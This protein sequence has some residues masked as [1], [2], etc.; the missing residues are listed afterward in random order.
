MTL[1]GTDQNTAAEKLY[2]HALTVAERIPSIPPPANVGEAD[3]LKKALSNYAILLRKL[4][5]DPEAAKLEARAA[6]IK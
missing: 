6:A 4:K 5:R 1:E 3:V 2:Q